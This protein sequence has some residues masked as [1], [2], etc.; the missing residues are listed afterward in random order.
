M[1][2]GEL[3]QIM[4]SS[5]LHVYRNIPLGRETLMQSIH[6]CNNLLIT[7]PAVAVKSA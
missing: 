2:P 5:L 7:G 4:Y 1:S 6:F 3:E